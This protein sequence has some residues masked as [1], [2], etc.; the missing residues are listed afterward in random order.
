MGG[1]VLNG[2]ADN[3]LTNTVLASNCPILLAPAMNTDMWEQPTV[4]RNW[5]QLQEYSRY[6]TIGPG[7]G[8][9]ACDRVGSGRMAEPSEIITKL[10]SLLYTKGQK[11]FKGKNILI[12]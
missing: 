9:L 5:Q 12:R 6:H 11:D 2:L 4:Q 8:L 7:S 10:Q 3:L 1:F